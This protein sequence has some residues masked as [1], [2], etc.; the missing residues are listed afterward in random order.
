MSR[1]CNRAQALFLP[2]GFSNGDEPDGSGKFIT[3]FLQN[4]RS[5]RTRY[6]DLL[7]VRDGL[8]LGICNGFQALIKLGLLPHGRIVKPSADAPT[9]T[10]NAI[11]RH[12][13]RLVRTKV[14]S[15]RSPWLMLAGAGEIYTVPVSHGEGRFLCPPDAF[16]QLAQ[17]GQIASQYVDEDGNA[18][19]GCAL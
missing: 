14:V 2:G 16:A 5:R 15:D 3:A 13:S 1:G 10:F 18:R 8:A 7:D 11:G 4:T 19:D 9:L 17:S 6:R 12:Q